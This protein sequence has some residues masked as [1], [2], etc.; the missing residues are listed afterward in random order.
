MCQPKLPRL[1]KNIAIDGPAASGKTTIGTIVANK[2]GY[3]CLDTGIM[4]R[5]VAFQALKEGIEIADETVVTRLAER[6]AIDIQPATSEDGRQFDVMI[7]GEDHTWDIRTAAVNA[8]VSEVSVYLGVRRAMTVQQR[9]IAEKG[10]I[11]MIGRDIGTVVLP[12]AEL[13]IYLDA[14]VEVRAQRR[15]IEDLSHG[16]DVC[17]QDVIESLRHRDE[18]DSGRALAPLKAAEDAVVIDSDKM[19]VYEVVEYVMGLLKQRG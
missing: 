2:I 14:S 1:P 6:I 11:V 5:A 18:I 16:K 12:D 7:N 10:K 8:T 17:L 13:K 15:Y 9:K 3:M 4:Y 19:T